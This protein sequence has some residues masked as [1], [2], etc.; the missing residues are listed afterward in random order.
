[1]NLQIYASKFP[2]LQMRHTR[3]PDTCAELIV[4]CPLTHLRAKF[5]PLMA[6]C[7]CFIAHVVKHPLVH[8]E[9]VHKGQI[10]SAKITISYGLHRMRKAGKEKWIWKPS[11]NDGQMFQEVSANL[12]PWSGAAARTVCCNS[13]SIE[14]P[15]R[16]SLSSD[17]WA[18][19]YL[20][21]NTQ[22]WSNFLPAKR[23]I[24]SKCRQLGNSDPLVEDV[25]NLFYFSL[26]HR[27][28]RWW[29]CCSPPP[30]VGRRG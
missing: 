29:L 8:S 4:S 21:Q 27:N 25:I 9:K 18:Q 14:H 7:W 12:K 6:P 24:T 2:A 11:V 3:L 13:N 1:M 28:A 20:L 17:L 23:Y 22:D 10:A 26:M 19:Q 5:V 16:Q 30:E 15:S